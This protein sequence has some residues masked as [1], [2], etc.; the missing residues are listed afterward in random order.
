MR[1]NPRHWK[2]LIPAHAL[3]LIAGAGAFLYSPQ[4]DAANN[5]ALAPPALGAEA[6]G[7]TLEDPEG[8]KHSLEDYRGK[9]VVL[10]FWATWCGPCKKVMPDMQKLHEKHKDQ[11]LVVIGMNAWE[12]GDAPAYMKQQGFDYKLLLNADD[13][14]QKYGVR[15]IPAFFVIA[16]DGKLAWHGTGSGKTTHDNMVRAI[17]RELNK[18]AY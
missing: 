9:V 17:E 4:A 7:W 10:D 14:A 5:A 1:I 18:I 8:E 16:P 6:P 12:R 13:A 11:G 2:P 15:G 3:G